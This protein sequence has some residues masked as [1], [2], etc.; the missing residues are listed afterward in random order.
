MKK[1]M[2][3]FITF[4]MLVGCVSKK[5]NEDL[6]FDTYNQI[7][8]RLVEQNHFDEYTEFQVILVYNQLEDIYRYDI[9]IDHPEIDMY[10]ITALSYASE[11]EDTM[12]PNIGIFD[13]NIYHL[14]THIIDKTQG[15]YKG[16]QLSG[17]TQNKQTVKLYISYYTDNEQTNKIEKYIEV[18]EK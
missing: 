12:C 13:K 1:I 14:S 15:Y 11:D 18:K 3:V 7:R 9:I 2:I 5:T 4:I 8:N 17:T 6:Q 16:I 10:N